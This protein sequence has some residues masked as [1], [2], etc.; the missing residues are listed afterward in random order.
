MRK[1]ATLFVM[2]AIL[3]LGL[4]AVP[5]ARAQDR[6]ADTM[7]LLKDKIRADKKLLV[8]TTLE[9][10]ESEAKLFWP[11]YDGYQVALERLYARTGRLIE[12][13]AQN[14]RSLDDPV[15]KRLLDDYLA[16]DSDRQT[17]QRD[18]LGRFRSALSER[19]VARYYQLENK[20][21]ALLN[22]ELAARIPLVP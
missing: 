19:K 14:Y 17:L 22:Y 10:T 15:A 8:A 18:Y 21:S 1:L 3:G 7:A 11:V 6:P 20:I 4:A 13:Y 12:D 5:D 9:L 2:F 16:L